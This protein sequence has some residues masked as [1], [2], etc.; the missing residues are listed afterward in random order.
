MVLGVK[1]NL[2]FPLG[3]DLKEIYK[4]SEAD[5]NICLYREYG[6]GLCEL[7]GKPTCKL[8]LEWRAQRYF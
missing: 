5:I 2:V 8:L 6:R 3:T 7:L 1:T 4:L